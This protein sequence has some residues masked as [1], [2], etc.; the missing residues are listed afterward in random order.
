M[1]LPIAA[2]ATGPILARGL[3][4]EDRGLLAAYVSTLMIGMYVV[5]YG[6]QDAQASFAARGLTKIEHLS[7]K[8]LALSIGSIIPFGAASFYFTWKL[9]NYSLAIVC[10]SIP[11]LVWVQ[12]FRGQMQGMQIFGALLAERWI[13]VSLRLLALVL[14]LAVGHLSVETAL[15]AQSISM[16]LPMILI[17]PVCLRLVKRSVATNLPTATNHLDRYWA[18]STKIWVGG[19]LTAVMLR[20]D[21]V[22]MAFFST[23]YQLGLYAVAVSTAEVLILVS[24]SVKIAL[25]PSA[26]RLSLVDF[27]NLF[28]RAIVL[29]VLAILVTTPVV[30]FFIPIVFGQEYA[31]ARIPAVILLGAFLPI[32]VLDLVD[33][34]LQSRGIGVGRMRATISAA[35]AT[36]LLLP[37]LVS[38]WGA[39]GAAA[40]SWIAYLVASIEI[41][42]VAGKKLHM[43]KY[44]FLVLLLGGGVRRHA[45]ASIGRRTARMGR[46]STRMGRRSERG[47]NMRPAAKGDSVRDW[48][49]RILLF[50]FVLLPVTAAMELPRRTQQFPIGGINQA[51]LA[52]FI[53]ALLLTVTCIFAEPV[54]RESK[55]RRQSLLAFLLLLVWLAL[56]YAVS[57]NSRG[58]VNY[59]LIAVIAGV[60]A[61]STVGTRNLFRWIRDGFRVSIVISLLTYLILPEWYVN[62]PIGFRGSGKIIAE[63]PNVQGILGH[64]NY[65]GL[66][67]ACAIVVEI[68]LLPTRKQISLYLSVI[69]LACG[70]VMLASSQ[71]RNA[72]LAA[73]LGG[74][75]VVLIKTGRLLFA[76]LVWVCSLSVASIPFILSMYALVTA[77]AP[78]FGV[79]RFVGTRSSLWE[80]ACQALT[81]T[82]L[83]GSGGDFILR[84]R[85]YVLDV[86]VLNVTHAH[87]QLLN[88]IGEGGLIA[89]LLFIGLV[90]SFGQS[91]VFA[92]P[93]NSAV[94]GLSTVFAISCLSETPITPYV[95]QAG[96]VLVVILVAATGA[97]KSRP[98]KVRSTETAGE[99]NALVR[100]S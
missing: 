30:Y 37:P 4:V 50:V 65:T 67:F 43:R 20:A 99:L 59:L 53:A 48:S 36:A 80:G 41:V 49:T 11:A 16:I 69:F 71:A 68:A 94:A 66:Y 23:T 70:S 91:K 34:L 35:I 52:T 39:V 75:A 8:R 25:L 56:S 57:E 42:R 98:D 63:Y 10:L 15:L 78:N 14:L 85:S 5:A 2:I 40:V 97:G 92:D 96:T 76:R 13:G 73:V 62:E 86:D 32:L 51:A 81:G 74:L 12:G 64:P 24:S 72:I 7:Q 6:A 38:T 27:A 54:V 87:N 89:V 47:G 55:G 44:E 100:A 83:T 58:A 26:V 82:L 31:G 19:L 33:A 46:R 61:F 93:K 22:L 1:A 84:A 45:S 77:Q 9:D 79:I 90:F 17:L 60:I 21:Q 88:L 18:F 95:T 28:R 29:G 3:G